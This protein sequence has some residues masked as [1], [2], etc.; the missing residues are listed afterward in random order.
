MLVYGGRVVLVYGGR[1]VLEKAGRVVLEKEGSP[2]PSF[3]SY[4]GLP[5]PEEIFLF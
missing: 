4:G 1:V 3:P 2:L 5:P